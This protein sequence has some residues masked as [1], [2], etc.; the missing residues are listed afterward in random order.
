MASRSNVRHRPTT[1]L[2]KVRAAD[3]DYDRNARISV[4]YEFSNGRKFE[5]RNDEFRPY[6]DAEDEGAG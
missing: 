6:T 4:E 5:R 2:A 1:L 3:P